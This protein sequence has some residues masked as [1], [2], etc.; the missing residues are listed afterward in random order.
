[1]S[2]NTRPYIIELAGKPV[3]IADTISRAAAAALYAK[4]LEIS[5]RVASAS[6]V[7]ALRTLPVL[8]SEDPVPE[9]DFES[10]SLFANA[11]PEPSAAVQ[12]IVQTPPVLADVVAGINRDVPPQNA[13]IAAVLEGLASG[14]HV[15]PAAQDAP[16][17]AGVDQA[18]SESAA[19]DVPVQPDDLKNQV[20][21]LA[22]LLG[23][24]RPAMPVETPQELIELLQ[25]SEPNEFNGRGHDLCRYF[26]QHYYP[27]AA[28]AHPDSTG[29]SAAMANTAPASMLPAE[30]VG[31]AYATGYRLG[32]AG[33]DRWSAPWLE[34]NTAERDGMSDSDSTESHDAMIR[35]TRA[36]QET[37]GAKRTSENSELKRQAEAAAERRAS[38]G[39]IVAK[40]RNV[41]GATWTGRG[42]KPRWLVEAL[43]AGK[44]LDE[45]LITKEAA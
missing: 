43:E 42:M 28:T 30:R 16:A 39:K 21:E 9:P 45:F 5:A 8:A 33:H 4:S 37:F 38:G 17:P 20:R 32:A 2:A 23:C 3:A 10:G 44:T 24:E 26:W 7:L 19:A 13:P 14:E 6:D 12:A 1:M 34:A 22:M 27:T 41:D 25:Q 11:A 29:L 35:G 40:Y 15:E 18:C 31:H 36:A